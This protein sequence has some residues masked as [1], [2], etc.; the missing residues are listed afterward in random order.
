MDQTYG[1]SSRVPALQMQ[2]SGFKP[3]SHPPKKIQVPVGMGKDGVKVT[4]DIEQ[5]F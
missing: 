2:S 5:R 4:G 3:Q 1:S